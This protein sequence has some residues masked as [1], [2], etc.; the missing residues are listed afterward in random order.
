MWQG[1]MPNANSF[2]A[3]RKEMYIGGFLF[4]LLLCLWK[5][6][7]FTLYLYLFLAV[8]GLHY[9]E[10]FSLVVACGLL[11]AAPPPVEHG[12]ESV[13]A[14]VLVAHELSSCSRSTGSMVEAR[15]LSCSVACGI[16]PTKGSSPCLLHWQADSVPL[17]HQ[18]SPTTLY[19]ISDLRRKLRL[20]FQ[21]AQSRHIRLVN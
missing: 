14:S 13:R 19:V 16:F 18:G 9:C 1:K 8:L 17:S 6:I 10:G 4:F 21:A 11:T 3:C 20:P 2:S 15:R 5:Q 7:F 12:H